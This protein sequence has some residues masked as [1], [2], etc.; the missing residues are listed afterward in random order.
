MVI[1]N[2]CINIVRPNLIVKEA[3]SFT[4]KEAGNEKGVIEDSCIHPEYEA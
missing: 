1:L 2:V 3:D 4:T